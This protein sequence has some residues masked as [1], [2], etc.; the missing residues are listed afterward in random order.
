MAGGVRSL[1][2]FVPRNSAGGAPRASAGC[3]GN[4]DKLRC[5]FAS[6][7]S[8]RA[9]LPAGRCG[10]ERCLHPQRGDGCQHRWFATG[11]EH[12]R[13]RARRTRCRPAGSGPG[14][15]EIAPFFFVRRQSSMSRASAS[16]R[17]LRSVLRS[18]MQVV[19]L[20][21]TWV[22]SRCPHVLRSL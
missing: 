5:R 4:I 19:F 11:G 2:M 18:K 7:A 9:V 6:S 12:G 16:A 21:Q 8:L 17:G 22:P 1:K 15:F 3:R 20:L 13:A 14:S 10:S